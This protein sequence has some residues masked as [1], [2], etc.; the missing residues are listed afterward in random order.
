MHCFSGVA[1]ELTQS[2]SCVTFTMTCRLI[3]FP[4]CLEE[5][6]DL[7]QRVNNRFNVDFG[8]ILSDMKAATRKT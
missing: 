4:V 1:I 8:W 3:P 6:W 2:V 5:L 7:A